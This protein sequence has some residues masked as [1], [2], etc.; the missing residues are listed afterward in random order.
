M[1]VPG[2]TY[3]GAGN[4]TSKKDAEKNAARDFVNYLVRAGKI[5]AAEVPS[6]AI[7]GGP[8]L[9]ARAA[10]VEPAPVFQSGQSPDDL[11]QAYRPFN[12]PRQNRFEPGGHGQSFVD[13]AQQQLKI[14][15]AESLD[16]NAAV[17]G[18]WTIEN[19]KAKLHQF[20]AMSK[21][22]AD[23]KYTSIGPDHSRFAVI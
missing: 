20:M 13:R 14:E 7:E 18:N 6:Q 15:E 9:P 2:F 3:I 22:Q 23:Y 17:H 5:N 19:A 10:D 1:V 4:S 11:G 12:D 8:A 21:I 16:V